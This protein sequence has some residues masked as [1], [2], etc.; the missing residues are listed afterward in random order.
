[1]QIKQGYV[2]REFMDRFVAVDLH[3]QP[4]RPGM[5]TMNKTAAFLW[6]QLE[7]SATR[8]QLVERLLEKYDIEENMAG[9]EVDRVLSMLRAK[10]VLEETE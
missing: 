6:K 1:M 10:G 7:T 5:I 9:S 4:G 3:N 8:Q 2:L